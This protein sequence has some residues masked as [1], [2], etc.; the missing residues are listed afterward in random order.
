M[1]TYAV[2]SHYKC[3]DEAFLKSTNNICFWGAQRKYQYILAE[4]CVLPGAMS[5]VKPKLCPTCRFTG[6][7]E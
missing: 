6:Y 1:K 3:L 2:G 4:K 5:E 7:L